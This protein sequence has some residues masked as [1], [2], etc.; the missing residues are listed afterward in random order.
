MAAVENCPLIVIKRIAGNVWQRIKL[1]QSLCL[2]ADRYNVAGEW[3]AGCRIEDSH[4][5]AK[6]V[7]QAG[8]IPVRSA[9]VGT[10]ADSVSAVWSRVHW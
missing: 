7:K 4:R 5:L 9:A 6:R 2:R 8:E 1:Q 3:Q 10:R